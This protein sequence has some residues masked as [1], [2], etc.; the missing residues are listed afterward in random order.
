MALRRRQVGGNQNAWLMSWNSGADLEPLT[1]TGSVSLGIDS[2]T[3]TGLNP[4][5]AREGS[6]SGYEIEANNE[7]PRIDFT[8]SMEPVF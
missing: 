8:D 7:E 1:E 6:G 3:G 2:R 4:Q 5:R